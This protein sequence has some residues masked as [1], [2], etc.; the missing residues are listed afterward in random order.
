[1]NMAQTNLSE[2]AKGGA[3]VAPAS[4]TAPALWRFSKPRGVSGVSLTPWLQPG[5]KRHRET[6]NRFNGFPSRA[7]AVETAGDFPTRLVHRAEATVLM[8]GKKRAMILKDCVDS[9]YAAQAKHFAQT[10][11]NPVSYAKLLKKEYQAEIK[12]RKE[13]RETVV[14]K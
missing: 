3:A 11:G 10:K 7:E 4:W 1:M 14:A 9:K 8:R 12:R 2:L 5:V 6:Q 13:K